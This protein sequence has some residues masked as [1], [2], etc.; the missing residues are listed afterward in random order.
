ML[1]DACIFR[2]FALYYQYFHRALEVFR[3]SSNYE[4]RERLREFDGFQEEMC[5]E[6]GY[7][8]CFGIAKQNVRPLIRIPLS[9]VMLLAGG[10][11]WYYVCGSD[12]IA[13]FVIFFSVAGIYLWMMS[14]KV[15]CPNCGTK[16][17]LK[18]RQR[19]TRDFNRY[20]VIDYGK[21]AQDYKRRILAFMEEYYKTGKPGEWV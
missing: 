11:L 15:V 2:G 1:P 5:D 6:C 17:P 9:V 20:D 14:R 13:W 10:A 21:Q 19:V 8:G 12:P 16:R 7:R 4:I 18:N 3:M